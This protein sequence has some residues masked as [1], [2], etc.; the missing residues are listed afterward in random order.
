M[1][2]GVLRLSDQP[3]RRTGAHRCGGDSRSLVIVRTTIDEDGAVS[4]VLDSDGDQGDGYSTEV[5]DDMLQRASATAVKIWAGL[6]IYEA[7]DTE[8]AE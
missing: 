6:H 7:D 5:I 4:V 1:A 3:R 8:A 2:R